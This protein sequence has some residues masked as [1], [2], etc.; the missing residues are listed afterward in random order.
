MFDLEDDSDESSLN[1]SM[2]DLANNKVMSFS[3]IQ[4]I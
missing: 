3:D 2:Q 4:S 1:Q